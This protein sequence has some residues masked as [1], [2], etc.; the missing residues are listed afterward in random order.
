M[1]SLHQLRLKEIDFLR[2]IAVLLVIFRHY[3][4]WAPLQK[5]G[6]IGVDLFFVLSGFLVSGLLFKEYRESGSIKT[7][8]FLIRRG[9]KIYPV[10]YAFILFTVIFKTIARKPIVTHDL[11]GELFFLQNYM[12]SLWNHTWSLAV[13]EHF[14][15]TLSLFLFFLSKAGL[16]GNKNIFTGGM[17]FT[18][19]LCLVLRIYS[20]S[21]SFKV[22][23]LYYSHLRLDSLCW[24]VFL[25]YH[26]HFNRD[27]LCSFVLKYKIWLQ[28]FFLAAI[29]FTP[30]IDLQASF[31]IPTVGF[32]L[33][34]LGFGSLLLQFL[35]L[36]YD[37][38]LK[39]N[40]I[41]AK[42]YSMVS[43]IGFYSYSIYVVHI[44]MALVT[45]FVQNK[46]H[47]NTALSFSVYFSLS[48]LTG[49]ITAR[50]IEIPF[51][52]IREKY[53]PKSGS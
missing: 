37:R 8:R 7:G 18:G 43:F 14:Y 28:L 36:G 29:S 13:E 27:H 12:G 17:I 31:F 49:Y 42:A 32:T 16:A 9:F 40:K 30:F 50:L 47:L 35:F 19:I 25:S 24:G 52:Q 6:W 21:A 33:L 48:V 34:Y 23:N 2:G 38:H 20:N 44:L 41:S 39:K 51:L 26:Y 1:Q 3:E 5:M 4:C 15:F 11:L 53:F 45:T 22:E 46:F 10:F